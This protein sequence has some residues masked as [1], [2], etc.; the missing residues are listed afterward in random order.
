MIGFIEYTVFFW[1]LQFWIIKL[2]FIAKKPVAPD[3]P[4]EE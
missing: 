1:N 3:P 4:H 2:T